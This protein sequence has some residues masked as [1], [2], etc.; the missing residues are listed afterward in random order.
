[1][2]TDEKKPPATTGTDIVIPGPS[3]NVVL[4]G[5]GLYHDTTSLT[6]AY[7]AALKGR[8]NLLAPV[9]R[10]DFIPMLHAISLRIVIFDPRPATRENRGS[11]SKAGGDLYELEG[12][13]ALT[14]VALDK[15][16]AAAGISWLPKYHGRLDDASEALYVRFRAC[17]M[18]R[19]V[20]GRVRIESRIRDTDLRPGGADRKRMTEGGKQ[21]DMAAQFIA[22]I[23]ESKACNRVVR[24]FLGIKSKY[25]LEE[26][27]RPFIVPT[28]V[29]DGHHE[30]PEIRREVA[31]RITEEALRGQRMIYGAADVAAMPDGDVERPALEH[32]DHG[33]IQPPAIVDDPRT[34]EE[35]DADATAAAAKL[36]GDGGKCDVCGAAK[37]DPSH[38]IVCHTQPHMDGCPAGGGKKS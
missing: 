24:A 13:V 28:L 16:A 32:R 3:G 21:F 2:A 19:D 18:M 33:G 4:Q 30:D 31:R 8:C 6:Q 20:D 35:L 22:P 7:H 27:K 11:A 34:D 37:D 38:C 10:V 15:I 23:T 5:Q 1:M 9:T 25:T 26:A 12:D 17:G 29:F 14:K 36:A